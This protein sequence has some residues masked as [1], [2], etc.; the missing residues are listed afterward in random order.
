[1]AY[2]IEVRDVDEAAEKPTAVFRPTVELSRFEFVPTG[3]AP[4]PTPA[5]RTSTAESITAEEVS[6]SLSTG[7]DVEPSGDS[8]SAVV[9]VIESPIAPKKDAVTVADVAVYVSAVV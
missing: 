7:T 5:P 8:S 6:I 4:T 9:R 1:M 3:I 2:L